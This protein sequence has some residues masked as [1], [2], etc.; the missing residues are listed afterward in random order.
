MQELKDAYFLELNVTSTSA[1]KP[2]EKKDQPSI[3]IKKRPIP[4]RKLQEDDPFA[5]EDEADAQEL[6][7]KQKVQ[8]KRKSGKRF[9]SSDMDVDADESDKQKTK[10]KSTR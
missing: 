5:S 8:A 2:D 3:A 7:Q 9:Q 1:A 4:K 10:K 6:E